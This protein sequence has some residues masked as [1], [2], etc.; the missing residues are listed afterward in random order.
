MVLPF[1]SWLCLNPFTVV[2]QETFKQSYTRYAILL[3]SRFWHI[4]FE[5]G[6]IPS[7]IIN[8]SRTVISIAPWLSHTTVINVLIVDSA[9]LLCNLCIGV[10]VLPF[11]SALLTG[12]I[13]P[14]F[15]PI[16][17]H[18]LPFHDWTFVNLNRTPQRW[19]SICPDSETVPINDASPASQLVRPCCSAFQSPS[20][21][22]SISQPLQLFLPS[23]LTSLKISFLDSH[24]SSLTRCRVQ[25]L[26]V[27]FEL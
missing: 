8:Q 12:H 13:Y 1:I 2:Y 22:P 24:W 15:H 16:I 25:V 19:C 5:L 7:E 20:W 18:I 23:L 6:P 3:M 26:G 21:Y 11:P 17:K 4:C 27:I 10:T 14:S 9:K